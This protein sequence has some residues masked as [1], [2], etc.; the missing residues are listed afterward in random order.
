[1]PTVIHGPLSDDDAL[2]LYKECDAVWF[3]D[4]R[5]GVPGAPHAV[6]TS[7]LHSDGY[8][9]S[10][11]VYSKT[12]ISRI[13]IAE[14][15]RRL[16]RRNSLLEHVDMV[17]SSSDS[18]IHFGYELARQLGTEAR[19]VVKNTAFETDRTAPRFICK[20]QIPEGC[21]VL[22]AEELI[23]TF[24]TTGAV[25]TAVELANPHGRIRWNPDVACG[26]L[27]PDSDRATM[28]FGDIICL[29]E[30]I[31]KSW[32]PEDCPLCAG[33]SPA[34]KPK[35]HWAELTGKQ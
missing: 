28:A 22:R 4:Y 17:V 30:K 24:E 25:R 21:N 27:R 18:A 13:L 29:A 12:W 34:V 10:Q 6:L 11:K 9:D 19:F 35:S 3:F 31:V 16:S 14:L 2:A 8:V 33:G 1:M 23:T 20:F 26:V 32:R 7:G 15:V 5:R